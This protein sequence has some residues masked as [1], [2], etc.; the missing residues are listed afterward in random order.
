M[1]RRREAA[2][3]LDHLEPARHLAERV[4]E[5]LAVLARSGSS[6]PPR[7]ARAAARG[8]GR[9]ARRASRATSRA[10]PG[11]PASRPGRRRR[12][13]RPS[14]SRPRRSGGR[15]R[16]CKTGP[17]RPEPPV[18]RVRPPIQ[19]GMLRDAR[20]RASTVSVMSSVVALGPRG[21]DRDELRARRADQGRREALRP[22]LLVGAGR[23]QPDPG[24]RRRGPL[25]LGLRRQ[26]LPR[27]RVAA[28][29]RLDRP[30]APEARRGDQGAGRQALHDRPA[31]GDRAAL[32]RSR[33]CSPR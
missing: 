24:R 5:H 10:R 20:R 28:R 21:D 15:S 4:G 23:A 1:S 16:G 14:R 31:D 6:R 2:A 19:C 13:P 18:R 22:P 12:P 27:L 17:L 30:P 11:T 29:Q 32:A 33:A 7:A 8:C 25:L 26:A 9:R 3:E